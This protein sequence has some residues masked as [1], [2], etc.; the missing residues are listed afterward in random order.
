MEIA[1]DENVL[2]LVLDRFDCELLEA[3]PY[4]LTG[5]DWHKGLKDD[6]TTDHGQRI[7]YETVI[8]GKLTYTSRPIFLIKKAGVH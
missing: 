3:I 6:I 5:T 4:M 8:D 7:L 2:I 1:T